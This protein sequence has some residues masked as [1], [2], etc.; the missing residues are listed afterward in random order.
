MQCVTNLLTGCPDSA[1]KEVEDALVSYNGI[2]EELA[3]LCTT[4][5]LYER[6]FRQTCRK[7]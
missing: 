2:Q 7:L 3:D 6:K 5:R 1:K 4:Q